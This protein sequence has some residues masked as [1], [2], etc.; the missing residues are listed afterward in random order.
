MSPRQTTPSTAERDMW[1]SA[2]KR[3]L[4]AGT[5]GLLRDGVY[6]TYQRDGLG[7]VTKISDASGNAM[8]MYAYSPGGTRPGRLIAEPL[9]IHGPGGECG[10]PDVPLPREGARSHGPPVP[11]KGP[12]GTGGL[13]DIVAEYTTSGS[14]I[15]KY[16]HGAGID[17][18]LG[19]IIGTTT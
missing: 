13:N 19:L 17:E 10:I 5:P 8:N 11:P 12:V 14:L 6:H 18:P 2:V 1:Q 3:H 4:L 15:R 7:S 9:P 16:V